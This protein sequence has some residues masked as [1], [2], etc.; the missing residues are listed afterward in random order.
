QRSKRTASVGSVRF[1]PES[2]LSI[3]P[4][5]N[6]AWSL[7]ARRSSSCAHAAIDTTSPF[8][9]LG[10]AGGGTVRRVSGSIPDPGA[11]ASGAID[12]EGRDMGMPD[13]D[14]EGDGAL[15]LEGDLEGGGVLAR[16]VDSGA[17]VGG[18]TN[19]RLAIV[20]EYYRQTRPTSSNVLGTGAEGR[21]A[22]RQSVRKARNSGRIRLAWRPVHGEDCRA[23]F[24]DDVVRGRAR[25]GGDARSAPRGA[26]R[27]RLGRAGRRSLRADGPR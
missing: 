23:T 17:N 5:M 21:A 15:P 22:A 8:A 2:T 24:A 4:A 12:P 3:H 14:A 20:G 19:A 11:G 18:G 9:P 10:S 7:A 6:G 25:R 26:R 16:G 1:R 13:G 27:W